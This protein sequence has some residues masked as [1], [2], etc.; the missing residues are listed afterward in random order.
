MSLRKLT[1]Q[2]NSVSLDGNLAMYGLVLLSC[3]IE[4]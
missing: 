4:K 3:V 1:P 2:G